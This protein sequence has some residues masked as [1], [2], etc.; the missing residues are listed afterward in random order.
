M[1]SIFRLLRSNDL[2]WNFVVNNYLLGKE[3]LAF[4]LMYWSVDGTRMPRTCHLYYLRH[5][6]LENNLIKPSHMTMLGQGIDLS[7]VR[8]P[9]YVVAG[10]ED[11]I[12]PWRSAHRARALFSGTTRLI[13]SHGGHIT[14]II[15]PPLTCKGF[16]SLMNH[17]TD[18][19]VVQVGQAHEAVVDGLGQVAGERRVTSAHRRR[20]VT[21][22]IRR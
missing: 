8:C 11:H 18:R 13:L 15:N 17:V 6:Y 3:P 16:Y 7:R 2:I 5:L 22:T 12:V 1:G 20:R 19:Y 9:C 10:T 21:R 4:D 14:S